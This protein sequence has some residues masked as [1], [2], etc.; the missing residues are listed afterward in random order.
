MEEWKSLRFYAS[1]VI[2]FISQM[3]IVSFLLN[4]SIERLLLMLE[5]HRLKV[6]LFNL[7]FQ[8]ASSHSK[9]GVYNC[10]VISIFYLF[11]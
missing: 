2:N 6:V 7:S 8:H 10:P 11:F 5:T 1:I 4:L 9:L 3:C